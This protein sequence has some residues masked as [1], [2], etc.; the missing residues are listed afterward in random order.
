MLL[1][2]GRTAEAGLECDRLR[3]ESG[4]GSGAG[5]AGEVGPWVGEAAGS[6]KGLMQDMDGQHATAI[7]T[8][9]AAAAAA[10][11]IDALLGR[12]LA[13]R[14]L[15]RYREAA[16]D[17]IAVLGS[18]SACPDGSAPAVPWGRRSDSQP[19]S[20]SFPKAD[21]EPG[22]GGPGG[23]GSVFLGRSKEPEM[24]RLLRQPRPVTR[25]A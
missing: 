18:S 9:A 4:P 15:R 10:S 5:G 20:S 24:L 23:S 13:L 22:P 19:L 11:N 1:K 7:T 21:S 17:Y 12:A 14:S 25:G 16:R 2:Q 3:D 6:N 8:F